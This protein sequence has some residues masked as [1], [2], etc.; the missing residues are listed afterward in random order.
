MSAGSVKYTFINHAGDKLSAG[1][2]A[3]Y[4]MQGWW[5]TADNNET[6]EKII[7]GSAAFIIAHTESKVIGIARAIG[8][9]VSDAYIQDVAVL[10]SERGLGI[11][12]ELVNRLCTKLSKKG[13]K[14]LGLIAQDNS[15]KFYEKLGFKVLEKASPMLSKNSYV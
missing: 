4:K 5:D 9:G 12:Y 6:L 13:Y 15:H 8:D 2:I 10:E 11:G 1:I 3:V 14:W 7:S